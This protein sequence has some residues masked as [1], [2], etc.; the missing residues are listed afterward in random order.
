M[1]TPFTSKEL[2]DV[3]HRK[4]MFCVLSINPTFIT[5]ATYLSNFDCRVKCEIKEYNEDGITEYVQDDIPLMSVC[6]MLEN[7]QY[8]KDTHTIVM[9]LF[10]TYSLM[11]NRTNDSDLAKEMSQ[12]IFDKIVDEFPADKQNLLSAYLLSNARAMGI[13]TNP[14]TNVGNLYVILSNSIH[15]I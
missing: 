14:A 13:S 15:N 6:K 10:T 12:N 5:S 4:S 8:F 1:D 7:K 2:F 3:L 9:D 11:L